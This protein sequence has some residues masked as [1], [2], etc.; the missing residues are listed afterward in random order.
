[1][2]G[3]FVFTNPRLATQR[4]RVQET[5]ATRCIILRPQLYDSSDFHIIGDAQPSF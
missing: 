5:R 1:M 4:P 3:L 2:Q